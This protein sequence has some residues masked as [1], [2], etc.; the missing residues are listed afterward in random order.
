LLLK[1][2]LLQSKVFA[3]GT[4]GF[5]EE[6]KIWLL[7]AIFKVHNAKQ[8]KSLKRNRKSWYFQI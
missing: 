6:N 5:G 4:K 8:P 2:Y 3:K 1:V 7:I